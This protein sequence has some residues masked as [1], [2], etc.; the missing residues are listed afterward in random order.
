MLFRYDDVHRVLRD[1]SL[2]VEERNARPIANAIDD[3]LQAMFEERRAG[4]DRARCSTSTRPTTTACAVSCRRCSRRAWS[5]SC[6]RACSSSS[7]AT[8]TTSR[9]RHGEI[10]LIADL[11]FPL[12]F[13][14]ISEMLGMPESRDRDQLREW[15]GAI[16]KTFDPILTREET[17]AAFDAADN[18]LAYRQRDDRVEARQP[19]RRPAHRAD[20]RR[21]RRRP[22][23]RA[24]S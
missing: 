24:T 9:A 13:V 1:P 7:T 6:A 5:R 19:G 21:G 17:L 15:S 4:G 16:V 23:H 11:A 20:R 2:S 12:P 10:D 8:S 3:D 14:V 22:A 18:M